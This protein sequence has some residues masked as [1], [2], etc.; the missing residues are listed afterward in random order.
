MINPIYYIG[1]MIRIVVTSAMWDMDPWG[2]AYGID[3]EQFRRYYQL[4][5]DR[6]N[7]GLVGEGSPPR[8]RPQ[9]NRSVFDDPMDVWTYEG[10]LT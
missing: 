7:D 6:A 2:T 5:F 10:F 9:A 1:A 4:H 3:L 8:A